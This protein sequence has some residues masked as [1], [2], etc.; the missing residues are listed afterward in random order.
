LIIK[1][2]L[3]G[4]TAQQREIFTKTGEKPKAAKLEPL[5]GGIK[6][7]ELTTADIRTWHRLIVQEVGQY[8]ANRAKQFLNAALRL[9]EED[10]R[11]TACSMP[12]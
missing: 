6:I 2:L 5:L 1:P 3:V 9:A 8:S 11:I 4:A 12:L 7:N 10:L